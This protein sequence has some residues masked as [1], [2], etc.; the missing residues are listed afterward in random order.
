MSASARSVSIIVPTLNEA[1]N[2]SLLVSQIIATGVPFQ[3]IIFVDDRST[4][5]TQDAIRGLA[6]QHPIRLIERETEEVGLAGAIM[7]GAQEARG[8]FLLVMDADLSH[9]PERI[10]DLLAP[11]LAGTADMA[12]GSR[13]VSGGATP[14][15][16]LWRR[17]LSRTAAAIAFPLTGVHDS[18]CGFFAIARKRLLELAPSTRGFKIAFETITRGHGNLRVVEI[19]IVFRDRRQGRSKMSAR[20]ALYFVWQWLR[21]LIR[22]A[23]NRSDRRG[24]SHDRHQPAGD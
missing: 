1:E 5:G 17:A 18:M 2:V 15:W 22:R 19:P 11:L 7:A 14:G 23:P 6:R 8:E 16:P 4:D 10:H 13:Y 21:A 12:I 9:P 20:V 3:E 24:G